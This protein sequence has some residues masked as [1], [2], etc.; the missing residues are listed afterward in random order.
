MK[1]TKVAGEDEEENITEVLSLIKDDMF[2]LPAIPT[3]ED[4]WC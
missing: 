1:R 4:E 3:I 2:L